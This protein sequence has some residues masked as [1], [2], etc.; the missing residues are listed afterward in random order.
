M[1]KGGVKDNVLPTEATAVVNFRILPGETVESVM[2]HVRLRHR[3]SRHW[4]AARG[5]SHDPSTTRLRH[6]TS[7]WCRAF[8]GAGRIPRRAGRARIGDTEHRFSP[9]P[10]LSENSYR[11]LPVRM[12]S[13]DLR[14]IHGTNERI[15]VRDYSDMVRF[16]IT[17]IRLG[18]A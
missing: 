8:G 14:R 2:A 17:L 18:T 12:S 11:F 5:A 7:L 16:Y 15:S 10:G 4:I 6:L 1:I 3:R 9:L 13:E